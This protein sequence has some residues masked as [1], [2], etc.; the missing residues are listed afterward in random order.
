MINRH[1]AIRNIHPVAVT[2]YEDKNGADIVEDANGQKIS[3]D[4]S[5][6]DAEV[7]RLNADEAANKYK[8][9]RRLAYKRESDHLYLEEARGEI[10]EGTWAAKVAEIKTRFP[11]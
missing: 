1:T 5:A 4:T 7:T 2:I 8:E 10:S 11:K 6:V 3:I 9:D